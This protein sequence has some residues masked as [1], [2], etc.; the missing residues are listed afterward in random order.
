MT[1]SQLAARLN[2]SSAAICKAWKAGRIDVWMNSSGHNAFYLD[3]VI[4]QMK[5][6]NRAPLKHKIQDAVF[7]D[8][9][10]PPPEIMMDQK[11]LYSK[12][13]KKTIQP[14]KV[15][16]V[17]RERLIGNA[18]T[19]NNTGDLKSSIVKIR[20]EKEFHSCE[21]EK[22]KVFKAQME[23]DV[24]LGKLCNVEDVEEKFSGFVIDA[25]DKILSISGAFKNKFQNAE[26][27]MVSF[28][29]SFI[30]DTFKIILNGVS[31]N[32]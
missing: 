7:S 14:I 13:E 11:D 30:S 21:L 6:R 1:Q 15:P 5:T 32:D 23:L 2:V 24:A 3:V 10:L 27:E 9:F 19:N 18:G 17:N 12:K 29:D 22:L 25:R 20:E 8:G 4:E 16:E 31:N 28:L 26:P